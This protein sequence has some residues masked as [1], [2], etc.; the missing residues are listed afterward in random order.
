[1][2]VFWNRTFRVVAGGLCVIGALAGPEGGSSTWMLVAIAAC[3][4]ALMLGARHATSRP[5]PVPRPSE[6]TR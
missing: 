5:T 1:M 2:T 3:S 4:S 6:V